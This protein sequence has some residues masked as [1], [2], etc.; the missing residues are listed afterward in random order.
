M[1]CPEPPCCQRINQSSQ[2]KDGAKP[3]NPGG[4]TVEPSH[5]CSDSRKFS[6]FHEAKA[7]QD[8]MVSG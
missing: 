5:S 7:L 3:Q 6:G 4:T 2:S 1:C 8:D